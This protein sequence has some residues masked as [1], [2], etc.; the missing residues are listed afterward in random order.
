MSVKRSCLSALFRTSESVA[1]ALSLLLNFSLALLIKYRT[2]R[3]LRTYSRVLLCNC[4]VDSLFAATS[5]LIEMV[6]N[7]QGVL[8]ILGVLEEGRG[9]YFVQKPLTCNDTSVRIAFA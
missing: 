6:L 3:E 9:S 2:T 7:I 5:Y 4:V 8:Q 1:A